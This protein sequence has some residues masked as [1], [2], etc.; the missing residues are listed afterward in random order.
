MPHFAFY[1][2]DGENGPALRDRTREAH[3]DYLA[4]HIDSYAIAG[5]LLQG[6]MVIGSLLLIEAEDEASARAIFEKDP[7]F[8][9][10]VWQSIRA[11]QFNALAGAWA[12]PE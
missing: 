11:A 2:R 10:G 5:P 12:K 3:L 8:E 6:D 7:Y 1:C 4:R 9:A